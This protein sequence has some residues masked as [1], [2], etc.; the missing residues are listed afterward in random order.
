MSASVPEGQS[1]VSVDGHVGLR[2]WAGHAGFP[3]SCALHN[4][5]RGMMDWKLWATL[6]GQGVN[7]GRFRNGSAA[8]ATVAGAPGTI[9]GGG[10]RF[11]ARGNRFGE[12]IGNDSVWL[13]VRKS[14]RPAAA[15]RTRDGSPVLASVELPHPGGLRGGCAFAGGA[16]AAFLLSRPPLVAPE[17]HQFDH[18]PAEHHGRADEQLHQPEPRGTHAIRP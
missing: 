9:P 5:I 2:E 8:R 16:R 18:R 11:A 1:G 4:D 12:T 7:F 3:R 17:D 10:D 13:D 6:D 15:R 14:F